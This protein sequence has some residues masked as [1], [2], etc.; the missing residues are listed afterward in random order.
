MGRE[1]GGRDD[2]E[3]RGVGNF[4]EVNIDFSCSGFGKSL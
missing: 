3:L 1:E 2:D 4:E